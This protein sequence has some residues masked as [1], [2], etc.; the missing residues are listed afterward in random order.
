MCL[1]KNNYFYSRKLN[2]CNKKLSLTHILFLLFPP[3]VCEESLLF[4]NIAL[5]C[6]LCAFLLSFFFFGGGFSWNSFFSMLN[7]NLNG[8]NERMSLPNSGHSDDQV[9]L[10]KYSYSS[11]MQL[12]TPRIQ[13]LSASCSRKCI[14]ITCQW[15]PLRLRL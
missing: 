1:T 10:K 5:V 14:H 2:N 7:R 9:C 12:C 4:F 3:G 11:M 15:K 6:P 13:C 8:T